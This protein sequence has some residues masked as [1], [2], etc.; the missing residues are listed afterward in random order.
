MGIAHSSS[1]ATKG[2]AVERLDEVGNAEVCPLTPI[3]D[4]IVHFRFGEHGELEFEGFGEVTE[5]VTVKTAYPIL[6]EAL[7][8]APR[9]EETGTLTPEGIEI[10]KAAVAKERL[11][12]KAKK[13][14]EPDTEVGR[15]IKRNADAPTRS[16]G[17][18]VRN[19]AR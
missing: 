4:V 5:D 1:A 14:A 16:V 10:V 12:I 9:D 15:Q 8:N 3:R 6:S 18:I 17:R 2:G 13:V 11:R 19:V 7:L